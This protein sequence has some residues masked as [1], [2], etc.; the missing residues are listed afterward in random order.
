VDGWTCKLSVTLKLRRTHQ[1]GQYTQ[2]DWWQWQDPRFIPWTH[3]WPMTTLEIAWCLNTAYLWWIYTSKDPTTS[4]L[5]DFVNILLS[6]CFLVKLGDEAASTTS[7]AW[8]EGH[9]LRLLHTYTY[10]DGRN[11]AKHL[12]SIFCRRA[13]WCPRAPW[14][15]DLEHR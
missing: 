11:P 6:N 8:V 3:Q 12:G 10:I 13:P 7:T 9:Q 14:W 5:I 15:R 4:Y 1:L 2:D